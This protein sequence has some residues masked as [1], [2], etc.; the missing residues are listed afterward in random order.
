MDSTAQLLPSF[1]EAALSF[2]QSM[3]VFSKSAQS[4]ASGTHLNLREAANR[5]GLQAT[6]VRSTESF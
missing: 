4:H 5:A 3:T 2:L 1:Q 6:A